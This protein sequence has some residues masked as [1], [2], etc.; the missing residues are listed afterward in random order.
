MSSKEYYAI[1]IDDLKGQISGK[2]LSMAT[3]RDKMKAERTDAKD[4]ISR[5]R[6]RIKSA[7]TTSSK[8]NLRNNIKS[9]QDQKQRRLD[10]FTRDMERYKREID[11]LKGRLEDARERKNKAK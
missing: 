4:D 2:R 7:T 10:S 5:L 11:S 6:D 8:A 1:Q 3:I 9:R